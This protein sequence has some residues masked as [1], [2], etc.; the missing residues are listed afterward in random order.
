MQGNIS[1]V[2]CVNNDPSTDRKK[3]CFRCLLNSSFE[4]FD[5]DRI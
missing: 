5:P 1:S 3:K 2:V 4:L